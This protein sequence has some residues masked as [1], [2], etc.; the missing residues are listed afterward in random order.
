A[1]REDARW[2]PKNDENT[3]GE[4]DKDDRPRDERAWSWCGRRE[5]SSRQRFSCRRERGASR[6]PCGHPADSRRR[7]EGQD[8][9]TTGRNS[10]PWAHRGRETLFHSKFTEVSMRVAAGGPERVVFEK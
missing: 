7:R 9:R 5:D 6:R 8:C 4:W 10:F 1:A 2:T 3:P